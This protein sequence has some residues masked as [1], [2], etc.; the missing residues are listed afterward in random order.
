M[1]DLLKRIA[2]VAVAAAV[3][4]VPAFADPP[5]PDNPAGA[6]SGDI[7][8]ISPSASHNA[9]CTG[10]SGGN[11]AYH[12]G[13]VMHANKTYAIY[14]VPAGYSVSTNYQSVING[15][16][17]DVAADSGKTSNVYYSDAQYTD[18]S[19]SAAYA[20]TF[21]G[22]AVD[23]NA[24]PANGCTDSYTSTCLSDAQIR[25]EIDRV[26]AANGWARSG[27][28]FFMFT[29]KGIGSCISSSQCAFSYYCA[30]H[31]SFSSSSGTT[32]Y[33]NMPYADTVPS[34]CDAGNH[35]NGDDA[36]AT[37]SVT[38]HEHNETVTDELGNAWYDRRGQENGDKCA[39]NFGTQLGGSS[40]SYYNQV[41]NGHHYEL[42]QEWS[43]K[44]SRCVLTGQ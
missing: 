24:L 29:A 17:T 9:C 39:W 42:Q 4:T 32:L 20:S 21:G 36:D 38:S 37:L 44:S 41:I 13:P 22:S 16:F 8:G 19:G 33:A 2:F 25:S 11:L 14:W 35:P 18:G 12:G 15:Y 34:Q 5:S 23:T 7:L 26:A 28:I 1:K 40:G 6:R 27:A 31:S 30:Y 43:N 10:T 3:L